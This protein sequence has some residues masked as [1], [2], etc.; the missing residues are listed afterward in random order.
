MS[1]WNSSL[2]GEKE[3]E[4]R[5][6]QLV[7][8]PSAVEFGQMDKIILRERIEI[9]REELWETQYVFKKRQR[10]RGQRTSQMSGRRKGETTAREEEVSRRKPMTSTCFNATEITTGCIVW[11]VWTKLLL[12]VYYTRLQRI[13]A[14]MQV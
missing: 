12:F 1:R 3:E 10:K 8:L 6:K 14:Y 5:L 11:T 4:T 9:R 2:E 13:Y 7:T